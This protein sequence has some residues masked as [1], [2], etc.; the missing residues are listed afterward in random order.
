MSAYGQAIGRIIYAVLSTDT[1]ILNYIDA[2]QI[3]PSVIYEK[4]LS[5]GIY[6]EV[7]AVNNVNTK[8]PLQADLSVAD[9]QVEVFG[10]TY[11]TTKELAIHAQ[12]ALDKLTAGAYGLAGSLKIDGCILTDVSDAFDKA[13]NLYYTSLAFSAR[14]VPT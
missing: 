11:E 12:N 13:N 4:S 5:A 9:F 8:T 2:D 1:D 6:Y 14:I 7:N 3:Q 10:S